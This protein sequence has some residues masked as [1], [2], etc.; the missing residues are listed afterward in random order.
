MKYIFSEIKGRWE[1][2]NRAPLCI[3]WFLLSSIL[4]FD[5]SDNTMVTKEINAE[6]SGSFDTLTSTAAAKGRLRK[7]IGPERKFTF[8]NL[9]LSR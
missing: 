5:N 3:G 9:F 8:Y 4:I 1:S 7:R 6:K 2:L